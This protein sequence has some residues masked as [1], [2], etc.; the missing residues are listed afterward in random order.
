MKDNCMGLTTNSWIVTGLVGSINFKDEFL[1]SSLA[2]YQLQSCSRVYKLL[3]E[4]EQR[5]RLPGGQ[6][7]LMCHPQ[8]GQ[9]QLF[10]TWK[11]IFSP[12]ICFKSQ[13]NELWHIDVYTSDYR[14]T[15]DTIGKGRKYI[16]DTQHRCV[17]YIYGYN[18]QQKRIECKSLAGWLVLY[19]DGWTQVCWKEESWKGYMF[20]FIFTSFC[21]PA[22]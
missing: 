16:Y 21:R 1:L 17:L 10:Y 19:I 15:G 22:T 3:P 8:L 14:A 13:L 5:E 6:K 18:K 4:G 2:L 7:D 9:H 11:F 12:N 20:F